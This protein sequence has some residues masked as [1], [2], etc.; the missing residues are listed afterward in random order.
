MVAAHR[1]KAVWLIELT[2][3]VFMQ[4]YHLQILDGVSGENVMVVI[5]S[6][7]S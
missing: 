6:Q 5:A 4:E 2:E 3:E 7:H 1:A